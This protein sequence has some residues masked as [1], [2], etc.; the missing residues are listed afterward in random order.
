MG[1]GLRSQSRQASS[2]P[3]VLGRQHSCPQVSLGSGKSP[4]LLLALLPC[5]YLS[6][7]PLSPA[8]LTCL[9]SQPLPQ[10]SREGKM[11]LGENCETQVASQLATELL[12]PGQGV[13][14]Q[15]LGPPPHRCS[16]SPRRPRDGL[17]IDRRAGAAGWEAWPGSLS[18]A[19]WCCLHG[20][21]A[22]G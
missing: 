2:G 13:L 17:S 5:P 11:G 12:R 3:P 7:L 19:A 10:G 18:R 20:V 22:G 8:S 16:C 1:R 14:G 15:A 9:W 6:P 21:Q 4:S